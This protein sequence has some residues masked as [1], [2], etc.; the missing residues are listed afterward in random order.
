MT[1]KK[2]MAAMLAAAAIIASSPSASKAAATS[3]PADI[4]VK[5]PDFIILHYYN[6]LT[7]NFDTP[8]SLSIKEGA[9]S[10]DV[11]WDGTVKNNSELTTKNLAEASIELDTDV[12]TVSIPNVWAVRG[13]SEKGKAKVEITIP[14]EGAAL[15]KDDSVIG[16]SNAKISSDEGTGSS[17]D[18]TLNGIARSRATIGGVEMDLDF[19]GTRLTGEHAGGKYIITATTM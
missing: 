3:G 11:A 19:S 6:S 7:L 4:A 5:V 14:E 18:V 17:V 16:L 1:I 9:N 13:F 8:E 15:K 12:T 10:M 2:Q